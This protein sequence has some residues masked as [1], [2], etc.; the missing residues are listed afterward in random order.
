VEPPFDTLDKKTDPPLAAL[1]GR[2]SVVKW[3]HRHFVKDEET[4]RLRCPYIGI[5]LGVIRKNICEKAAEGGHLDIL[6]PYFYRMGQPP[7]FKTRYME[8]FSCLAPRI[9]YGE[10]DI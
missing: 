4:Y 10:R 3:L 6:T 1:N 5:H 9:N 8:S 7:F 2:L